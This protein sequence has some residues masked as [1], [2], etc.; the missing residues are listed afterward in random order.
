MVSEGEAPVVCGTRTYT[1]IE[2]R[3]VEKER[4]TTILE[5]HKWEKNFVIETRFIGERELTDQIKVRAQ[6]F[7]TPFGVWK[8]KMGRPSCVSLLRK[9]QTDPFI[10]LF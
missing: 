2:D 8:S 10:G 6:S 3:P 9:H 4:H 7:R 1:V 5:H